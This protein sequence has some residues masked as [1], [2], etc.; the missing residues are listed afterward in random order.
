MLAGI[1]LILIAILAVMVVVKLIIAL[2]PFVIIVGLICLSAVV[3][4]NSRKS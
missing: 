1:V 4:R 3:L 2:L